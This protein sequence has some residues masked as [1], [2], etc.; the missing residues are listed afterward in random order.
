MLAGKFSNVD[1]RRGTAARVT[2]NA[3]AEGAIRPS[4]G[5]CL[6][7]TRPVLWSRSIHGRQNSRKSQ[8]LRIPNLPLDLKRGLAR[9]I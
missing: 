9:N 7:L 5:D 4:R 8:K 6:F 3:L 2:G 1:Q